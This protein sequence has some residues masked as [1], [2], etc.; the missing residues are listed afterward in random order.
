MPSRL[1]V[2]ALVSLSW[3]SAIAAVPICT[4]TTERSITCSCDV[5]TLHPLQ[6]AVGLE[7]V[8]S[9][10]EKIRSDP[11]GEFHDLLKDPIKVV[12]GPDGGLYI[13]DHHHGADAWRL[14]GHPMA[15]CQ[16]VDAAAYT[17]EAEFWSDLSA[18]KLV[19]LE[20]ADGKAITPAQLPGSL[21]AMPDDPYRSLAWRL[22][23]KGG[24]CRA[25]MEHVEFAEFVWADWLRSRLPL[26]SATPGTS[27]K[28][29]VPEALALARSKDASGTPGY[30]GDEPPGYQ[31]PDQRR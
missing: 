30:V 19:H 1:V 26:P 28:A 9:K 8:N 12:H 22:R 14:A 21:A 27:T 6:G 5:G 29:L 24:F 18:R 4:S 10:A 25:K 2:S 16:F 13:T 15:L 20:G 7:E 31:C 11:D 3:S 17:G 23:K